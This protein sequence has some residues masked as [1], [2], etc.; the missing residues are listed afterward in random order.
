[1]YYPTYPD[2]PLLQ[3]LDSMG[4][5]DHVA[6]TLDVLSKPPLLAPVIEAL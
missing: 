3:F 5:V 6:N 4:T 1:M 2:R